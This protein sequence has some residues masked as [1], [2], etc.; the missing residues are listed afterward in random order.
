MAESVVNRIVSKNPWLIEKTANQI[1]GQYKGVGNDSQKMLQQLKFIQE[2]LEYK[3]DQAGLMSVVQQKKVAKEII[4]LAIEKAKE[5]GYNGPIIQT[6]SDAQEAQQ[7]EDDKLW[8]R[9]KLGE[10]LD[11]LSNEEKYYVYCYII[12]RFGYAKGYS[13]KNAIVCLY[14]SYYKWVHGFETR[15]YRSGDASKDLKS[16][17][18]EDLEGI[19]LVLKRGKKDFKRAYEEC[20]KE[21]EE[22]SQVQETTK[23]NKVKLTESALMR[24]IAKA[25]NEEHT[26]FNNGNMHIYSVDHNE[27]WNCYF[28]LKYCPSKR[29]IFSEEECN[30][31][32]NNDFKVTFGAH[33]SHTPMR[34]TKGDRY[35]DPEEESVE[36]YGVKSY[37]PEL[38][39]VYHQLSE[40]N[41]ECATRLEEDFEKWV[42]EVVNG[43][44][45]NELE[46]HDDLRE[47]AEPDWEDELRKEG[48]YMNESKKVKLTESQLRNYIYE[49]VK[50]MLDA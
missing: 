16:I 42:E 10:Y 41:P 43:E 40:I 39:N 46:W 47:P 31:I 32:L 26:N 5:Q 14:P 37:D 1:L 12:N 50:R 13:T 15:F 33:Y 38:D 9:K 11:S 30:G 24:M 28:D 35:A 19:K 25:V 23:A 45:E 49:K 8:E 34:Y 27:G 2:D 20:L 21:K 44:H 29:G 4:A 22:K 36:E 6:Q 17:S 7:S 48:A 18:R 3:L